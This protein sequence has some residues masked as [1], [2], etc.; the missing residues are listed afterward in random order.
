MSMVIIITLVAH[1][2]TRTLNYITKLYQ[3]LF[4]DACVQQ[5]LC[6]KVCV[7][8]TRGFYSVC[9]HCATSNITRTEPC[10]VLGGFTRNGPYLR[11][12]C[13][14]STIPVPVAREMYVESTECVLINA[15]SLVN[16]L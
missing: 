10:I 5:Y 15:L 9:V 3:G 1:I 4:T 16:L 7:R 8:I 11:N 6:S 2:L 13:S 14:G 12:S